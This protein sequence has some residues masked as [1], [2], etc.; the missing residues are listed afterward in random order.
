[1]KKSLLFFLLT[2]ALMF[3]GCHAAGNTDNPGIAN[4]TGGSSSTNTTGGTNTQQGSDT[5]RN[6]ELEN[7]LQMTKDTTELNKKSMKSGGIDYDV[8]IHENSII[9]SYTFTD[10][11]KGDGTSNIQEVA[12]SFVA[13]LDDTHT[14]YVNVI[15]S[16]APSLE[17]IV[18][19]CYDS[20]G[21]VLA[22][23]EYK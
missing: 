20:S 7:Y 16:A 12:E 9:Y 19:V 11:Y 2:I 17:S 15:R 6:A 14:A 4:I 22:G 23:K 8:F 5:A 10:D 18:M 13:T 1:M 3:T 21:N